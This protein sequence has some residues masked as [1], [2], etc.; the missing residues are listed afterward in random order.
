MG[1]E[2]NRR[3]GATCREVRTVQQG[4]VEVNQGENDPVR[5]VPRTFL[6]REMTPRA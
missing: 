4:A 5:C 2:V 3:S 1:K 6:S